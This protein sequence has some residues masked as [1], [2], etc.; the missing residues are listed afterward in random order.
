MQIVMVQ[1]HALHILSNNSVHEAEL[2]PKEPLEEAGTR[3]R[4]QSD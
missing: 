3:R 2:L 4:F 1:Y